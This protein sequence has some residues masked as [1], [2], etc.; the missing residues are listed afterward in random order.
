MK[1]TKKKQHVQLNYQK[2]NELY[3]IN[4]IKNSKTQ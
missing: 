1:F 3:P 2:E 4:N